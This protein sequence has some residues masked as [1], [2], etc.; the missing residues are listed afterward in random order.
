MHYE[1]DKLH[2][3]AIFIIN[4][5][6]PVELEYALYDICAFITKIRLFSFSPK[7]ASYHVHA[8]GRW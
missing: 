7:N 4:Q 8:V 6:M 5:R 1:G 2:A 3:L